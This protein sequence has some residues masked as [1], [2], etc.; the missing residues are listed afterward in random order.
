MENKHPEKIKT[1]L[2][3]KKRIDSERKIRCE[4][5]FYFIDSRNLRGK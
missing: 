2:E 4:M 1:S 5:A 3:L